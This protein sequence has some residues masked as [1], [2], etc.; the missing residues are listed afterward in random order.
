MEEFE[1]WLK[2]LETQTL[3]EELK[4]EIIEKI[5]ELINV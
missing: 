2:S 4:E 3:T 5:Y 1:E